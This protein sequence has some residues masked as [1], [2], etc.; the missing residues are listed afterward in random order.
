MGE[1]RGTYKSKE[2]P[3]STAHPTVQLSTTLLPSATHSQTVN[4]PEDPLPIVTLP[5]EKETI[6]ETIKGV[7]P[8]ISTNFLPRRREPWPADTQIVT[9]TEKLTLN[10]LLIIHTHTTR[11]STDAS[12]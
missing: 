2:T 8:H 9:I 10:T 7:W 6:I 1:I 12:R 11:E 3:D 5:T 4:C